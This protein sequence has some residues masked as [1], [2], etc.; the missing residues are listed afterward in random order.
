[1]PRSCAEISF[2]DGE[3][4]DD[5]SLQITG[6]ANNIAILG[7]QTTEAEIVKKMLHVVPD[8]LEQVAISIETLLDV[9]NLSVEELI[10]RMCGVEDR[11][12]KKQTEDEWLAR[13]RISESTGSSSSGG[14]TVGS[15]SGKGGRKSSRG[16][17]R[18]LGA[19]R[20]TIGPKTGG[21]SPNLNPRHT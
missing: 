16:R 10:G 18:G 6:L 20:R 9:H 8:H 4:V 11:K 21:A 13:L 1:M 7:G 14:S 15:N 12:K 19:A 17:G 2:R 5:F 3:T